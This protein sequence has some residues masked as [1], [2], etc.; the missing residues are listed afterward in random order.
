MLLKEKF[1]T[2]R[3]GIVVTGKEGDLAKA[4]ID[5]AEQVVTDLHRIAE[6]QERMAN[7]LEKLVIFKTP[8]TFTP[9]A[10]GGGVLNIGGGFVVR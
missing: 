7:A 10:Q 4:A 1:D 8:P 2:I 3:N 5:I 6:A 9:D